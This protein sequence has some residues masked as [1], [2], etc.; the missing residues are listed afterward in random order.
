[1]NCTSLHRTTLN[2]TTPQ[3]QAHGQK[4]TKSSTAELPP[5]YRCDSE[6]KTSPAVRLTHRQ[7][8]VSRN[9]QRNRNP[10][11]GKHLSV[12]YAAALGKSWGHLALLDFHHARR[13]LHNTPAT[14]LLGLM[15]SE[16]V[17]VAPRIASKQ[18]L[19][20]SGCVQ[21]TP[22]LFERLVESALAT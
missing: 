10:G 1:M 20:Q 5:P 4:R 2:L 6:R 16:C 14:A 17:A 12:E 22:P 13:R 18:H 3:A 8:T 9:Y 21:H 7:G 11:T 15:L 19:F